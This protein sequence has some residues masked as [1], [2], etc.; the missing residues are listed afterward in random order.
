MGLFN[1][2]WRKRAMKAEQQLAALREGLAGME[3][4][5]KER[6]ALISIVR[7]DGRIVRFGFVRHDQI[8]FIEMIG[9]WS[10]DLDQWK[11]DLLQP[12][13]KD[14]GKGN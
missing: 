14:D 10:D 4:R 13:G 6:A 11:R 5:F 8:Y 12:K 2:Y 3:L 7:I 9:S 1:G